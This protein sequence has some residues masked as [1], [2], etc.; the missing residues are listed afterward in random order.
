MC[1]FFFVSFNG[2]QV[3]RNVVNFQSIKVAKRICDPCCHIEAGTGT[4]VIIIIIIVFATVHFQM[5]MFVGKA[6]S[7]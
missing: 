6:K 7:L 5:G 1:L 3:I 4:C 2:C